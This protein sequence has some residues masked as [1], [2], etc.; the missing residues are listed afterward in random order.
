MFGQE[1]DYVQTVEIQRVMSV[2]ASNSIASAVQCNQ[3]QGQKD[4][5]IS[6]LYVYTSW[7]FKKTQS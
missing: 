4:M 1:L 7:L 5:E 6:W 2:F 3:A